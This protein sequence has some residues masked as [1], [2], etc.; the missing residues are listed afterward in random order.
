MSTYLKSMK[1]AGVIVLLV[2]V[3]P[4]RAQDGGTVE[5]DTSTWDVG[6]IGKLN[7]SQAGFQNWAEGGVNTLALSTGVEGIAEQVVGTW[8]QKHSVRLSFGI[9]KQDTLAFRK[10]EDLIRLTTTLNYV[11]EG[12]LKLFQPTVSAGIRSQFAPGF[13]FEKNPF[14]DGRQPPVK[15]S[16]FLSPAT[17]TQSA[18]FAWKPTVWFSQRLGLGAKETVVMIERLR[19]LYGVDPSSSTRFEFGMEAF[20]DF[21]KEIVKNV[22]YKSTLGL[23]AAF[24]NPDLPDYL[25][26]NLVTM[27]VNSWMK[28]NFEWSLLFDEDVSS[29]LQVKEVFS[30]GISYAF[31]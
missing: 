3:A 15:V 8:T 27:K 29:D 31:L 10:A 14:G 1:W 9:V 25:W 26:E 5:A 23:F 13:N 7:G 30:V 22:H 18:G 21:D 6:L 16:D 24:N 4:C 28:V 17:F 2:L 11:G 19:T 12:S 20:T